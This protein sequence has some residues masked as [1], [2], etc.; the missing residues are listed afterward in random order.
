M[1]TNTTNYNW[2]KPDY[3]DDAD[4]KD[5][6]DNFDAIDAQMKANEN[7]ISAIKAIL[8]KVIDEGAKN[9]FTTSTAS[10]NRATY[11]ENGDVIS[12]EG[13]GTW[14][15]VMFKVKCMV[16]QN[17]LSL[18]VD[19]VSSSACRVAIAKNADA[20]G[21][22]A[23]ETVTAAGN[24]NFA[25]TTDTEDVYVVLYVNNSSTQANTSLVVSK[26]MLCT[27]NEWDISDKYVPYAPTN[28]ELY[29]MILAIQ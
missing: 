26:V 1:A 5:L 8:A 9:K 21:Q 16:G 13:T 24:V 12:V 14:A 6:N 22:L 3:E 25:F 15:R 18:K 7:N 11:T 23:Y 4:I 27:K 29:E 28:R 17:V 2:T 20:T 19:S 10:A